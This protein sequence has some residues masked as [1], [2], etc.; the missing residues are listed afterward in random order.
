M[1]S[2][3][4]GRPSGGVTVRYEVGSPLA[5]RGAVRVEGAGRQQRVDRRAD[6]ASRWIA[7]KQA[8]RDA[9]QVALARRQDRPSRRDGWLHS[10]RFEADPPNILD[11]QEP[12]SGSEVQGPAGTLITYVTARLVNTRSAYGGVAWAH[13]TQTVHSDSRNP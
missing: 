12:G 11:E 2:T 13:S 3:R 1:I 10:S 7:V 4:S 5:R 6:P 8:V 9:V